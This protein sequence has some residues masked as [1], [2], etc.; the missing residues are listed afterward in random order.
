MIRPALL[1]IIRIGRYLI[2]F[3]WCFIWLFLLV[4]L[5]FAM[6]TGYIGASVS[7]NEIFEK[8]KKAYLLVLFLIGMHGLEVDV[9][10][11]RQ[12]KRVYAKWI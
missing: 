2:P 3:P 5:P 6:A 1:V 4:L 8:L 11:V 10:L 7:E 12:G 9:N